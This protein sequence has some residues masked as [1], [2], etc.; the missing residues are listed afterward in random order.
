MDLFDNEELFKQ[1]K[2]KVKKKGII[3]ISCIAVSNCFNNWSSCSYDV[4]P[5]FTMGNYC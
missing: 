2:K 1:E 5:K 3:I 4:F